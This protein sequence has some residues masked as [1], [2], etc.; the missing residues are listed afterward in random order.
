MDFKFDGTKLSSK[1][2]IIYHEG[3]LEENRPTSTMMYDVMKASF[4]DVSYKVSY[5][6][7]S[8][9]TV[10]FNIMKDPCTYDNTFL[11]ENDVS[12]MTS[13]LVRK[14]HKTFR[15]INDDGT[16][17]PT[18]YKVQNTV[19]KIITGDHVVGLAVTV[20]SHAPYGFRTSP[21]TTWSGNSQ[22]FTVV[23]DEEGYIYPMMTITC[24]AAGNLT[25]VNSREDNRITQINNVVS[26]EVITIIG[27]D[28]LQISTSVSGH[29]LATDFNYVFPRFSVTY[30]DKVNTL[31]TNLSSDKEL[32]YYGIR[33]VGL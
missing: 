14:Q 30:D 2:Y 19:E 28:T 26:G 8:N 12:E 7:E 17:N 31:T 20:N 4:S 10:T 16:D 23:S 5:N 11:T 21:T 33:K 1:G 6:Y 9:Y 15:Y 29:N 13:W 25:I 3:L 27:V 24:N 18:W 32:K 22:Q